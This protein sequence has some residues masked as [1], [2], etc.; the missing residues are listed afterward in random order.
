V[1]VSTVSWGEAR[2]EAPS[3]FIS[4]D[5]LVLTYSIGRDVFFLALREVNKDV[6][7]RFEQKY[8]WMKSEI[9]R[10]NEEGMGAVTFCQF[11]KKSEILIVT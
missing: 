3:K 1:T 8:E 6:G 10:V 7:G 9:L 11:M 2:I 5:K 4:G